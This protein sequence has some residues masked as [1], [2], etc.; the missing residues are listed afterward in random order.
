MVRRSR[1]V[2]SF[3]ENETMVRNLFYALA[4]SWFIAAQFGCEQDTEKFEIPC[5]D[6]ELYDHVN[7]QCVERPRGMLDAARLD[8]PV[9]DMGGDA[10]DGASTDATDATADIEAGEEMGIDPSCDRDGDGAL[11]RSCGGDDCD[12]LDIARSPLRIEICDEIDN[13]CTEIN[14]DGID[15]AFYAHS[16]ADLY[17][18]DPFAKT[19]VKVSGDLPGLNDIDTHPDGTLYGVTFDGLYQLQGTVWMQIGDFGISVPPD[20]NGMAIDL[21]GI[22]FVTSRNEVFTVDLNSSLATPIGSLGNDPTLGEPFYSSGDCVVNKSN[23]LYMTSKHDPDQDHLVLIDSQSGAA[24]NVGPIGHK[25]VFGL[26]SAWGKLYGLLKDGELVEIDSRD[27][28]STLVT[29]FEDV[30]WYGAASTPYR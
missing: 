18:V 16:G 29:T 21:D 19:A 8:L 12:D 4:V 30:V 25:N 7:D 5:T 6:D 1:E 13:D 2:F 22:A 10:Q 3:E 27:G 9:S 26:T 20:P 11:S 23:T 17:R 14:N 24:T 15:C 28:A